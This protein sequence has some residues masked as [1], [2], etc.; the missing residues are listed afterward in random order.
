[1]PEQRRLADA[2]LAFYQ[3]CSAYPGNDSRQQPPQQ[4]KVFASAYEPV[5]AHGTNRNIPHARRRE[6]RIAFLW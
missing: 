3:D 4:V 6:K 1:M 5:I 2:L